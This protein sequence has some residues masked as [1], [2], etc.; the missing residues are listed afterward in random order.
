[1]KLYTLTYSCL[2]G[3]FGSIVFKEIPNKEYIEDTIQEELT[4]KEY[5]SLVEGTI[6]EIKDTFY[7]LE[8]QYL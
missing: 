1:M 3:S 6:I 8:I 7:I 5:D 4:E 2:D